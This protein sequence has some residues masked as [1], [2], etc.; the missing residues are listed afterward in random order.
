MY[1]SVL[2][3]LGSLCQRP[4][5]LHPSVTVTQNPSEIPRSLPKKAFHPPH[6]LHTISLRARGLAMIRHQAVTGEGGGGR[7]RE[8][9]VPAPNRGSRLI[10]AGRPNYRCDAPEWHVQT[11]QPARHCR[12]RGSVSGTY[13]RPTAASCGGTAAVPGAGQTGRGYGPARGDST[14][15]ESGTARMQREVCNSYS[16]RPAMNPELS[17]RWRHRRRSTP[18]EGSTPPG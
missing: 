1:G 2:L 10:I 17:Q 3:A 6:K 16:G 14:S 5:S 12:Q 18:P 4:Y 9:A 7:C 15:A 11:R 13:S 8:G